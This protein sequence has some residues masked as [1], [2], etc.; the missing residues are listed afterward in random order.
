VAIRGI[1]DRAGR[2]LPQNFTKNEKMAARAA[3]RVVLKL[4]SGLADS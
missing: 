1:S 2:P 4:V 3:Q